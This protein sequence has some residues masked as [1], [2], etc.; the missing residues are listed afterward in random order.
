MELC[1]S[2]NLKQAVLLPLFF[3]LTLSEF[4]WSFEEPCAAALEKDIHFVSEGGK[5]FYLW[6]ADI[7]L[8]NREKLE[9]A[10]EIPTS[11]KE[12]YYER[13]IL[14]YMNKKPNPDIVKP[15]TAPETLYRGMYLTVDELATILKNGFNPADNRWSAFGGKAV[16][17]TTSMPEARDYIFHASDSDIPKIGVVFKFTDTKD[18][19]LLE[20]PEGNPHYTIYKSDSV[21]PPE[22]IADVFF[23]TETHTISVE[24][25]NSRP[26]NPASTWNTGF[27]RRR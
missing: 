1:R 16:Y 18:F 3:M 25:F 26:M 20:S 12:G 19:E 6:A 24:D 4:L 5:P 21:I 17:T 10:F 15:T 2:L 11:Y 22:R 8:A 23:Y 13:R 27:N 14:P 7:V 9:I